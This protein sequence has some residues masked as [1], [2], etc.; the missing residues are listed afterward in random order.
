MTGRDVSPSDVLIMVAIAEFVVPKS[1]PTPISTT[2]GG[3]SAACRGAMRPNDDGAMRPIV[4]DCNEGG[5]TDSVAVVAIEA[6]R[7]S[8]GAKA[9]DATGATNG[10]A[11]RTAGQSRLRGRRRRRRTRRLGWSLQSSCPPLMVV[12]FVE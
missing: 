6:R 3:E 12:M 1:T 4:D 8:E 2:E 11:R 9:H 10:K 5:R 7:R